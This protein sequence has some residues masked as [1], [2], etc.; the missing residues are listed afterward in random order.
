MNSLDGVAVPSSE[1]TESVQTDNPSLASEEDAE[2][3]WMAS[4]SDGP[5]WKR[6]DD[7]TEED[8][9]DENAETEPSYAVEWQDTK[10]PPANDTYV[11]SEA[12]VKAVQDPW[13]A[14]PV[15]PSVPLL[16]TSPSLE[17]LLD[18]APVPESTGMLPLRS[19]QHVFSNVD[20][21]SIVPLDVLLQRL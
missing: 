12:F 8:D 3:E 2:D 14:T 20:P 7:A 10:D 21:S 19:N 4:G 18:D 1:T 11:P 17:T 13:R 6:S 9:N 15:Q 16:T 5:L